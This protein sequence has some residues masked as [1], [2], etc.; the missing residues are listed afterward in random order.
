MGFLKDVR[1]ALKKELLGF[2]LILAIAGFPILDRVSTNLIRKIYPNIKTTQKACTILNQEKN[3]LG[4]KEEIEL[5]VYENDELEEFGVGGYS[6]KSNNGFVIGSNI[7]ELDRILIR[8]ELYHIYRDKDSFI[9]YVNDN[10]Q[11]DL[12]EYRQEKERMYNLSRISLLK[13]KIMYD[14]V[15]EPRANIYSVTGIKF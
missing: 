10:K 11:D 7:G 1:R 12:D 3:K 13:H 2:V 15:Q 5:R 14:F 8:H 9:G 6:A 4:I